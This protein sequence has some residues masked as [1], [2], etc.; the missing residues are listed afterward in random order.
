M[1]NGIPDDLTPYSAPFRSTLNGR[2]IVY[3]RKTGGDENILYL[4]TA[5]GLCGKVC[6]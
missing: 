1:E 5:S 2:M 4:K 3:L 6:L